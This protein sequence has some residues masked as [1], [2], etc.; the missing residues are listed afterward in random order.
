MMRT[1]RAFVCAALVLALAHPA[2][3]QLS[4]SQLDGRVTDES[5]AVLPGATVT[6]TQTDTGF[7]RTVVTDPDGTYILP[8]LPTG[9]YR[10]EVMLAGFR[11]Y[12]QTGIVLQVRGPPTSNVQL[13]LGR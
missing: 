9:R 11:S 12:A 5:S 7:T 6:V 3:A 4:T 10:L 1:R 13:A 2:L 8:N